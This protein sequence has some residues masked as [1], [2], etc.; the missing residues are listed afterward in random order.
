MGVSANILLLIASTNI[1]YNKM[2]S[3]IIYVFLEEVPNTLVCYKNVKRY[4]QKL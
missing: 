4:I 3:N 1:Q 2:Y